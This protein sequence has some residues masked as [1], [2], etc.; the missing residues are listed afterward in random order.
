MGQSM[1]YTE[2]N[3]SA[4]R[5]WQFEEAVEL[6][7]KKQELSEERKKLEEE[8]RAFEREKQE[9][10]LKKQLDES[11]IAQNKRLFDMKWKVLEG[12]LKKLAAEKEQ[13]AKQRDFYRCVNEFEA[14][15]CLESPVRIRGG[16]FFCGVDSQDTLKKRYKDLI[17]IYHPDNLC[18]DKHVLQE[19]NAEYE[20]LRALYE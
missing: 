1:V 15:F 19:I 6:E 12:E 2:E 7:H 17:K 10:S 5:K 14:G 20:R 16:T 8:R 9:F 3:G 4:L 11:S 18:G 13:V